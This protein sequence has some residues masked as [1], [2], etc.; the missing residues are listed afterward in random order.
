MAVRVMVAVANH[1]RAVRPL[2]RNQVD[3]VGRLAV[4]AEQRIGRCGKFD[5]LFDFAERVPEET[6]I[7]FFA[8]F[9][10]GGNDARGSRERPDVKPVQA[11]VVPLIGG[12]PHLYEIFPIGRDD[13][14]AAAILA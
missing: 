5:L 6:E 10:A 12:F 3:A 4:D 8:R 1:Q 13:D 7:D 14:A 2:H 11:R 9:S